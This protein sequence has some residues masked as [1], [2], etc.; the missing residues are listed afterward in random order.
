M[1]KMLNL[2]SANVFVDL[3]FAEIDERIPYKIVA[4]MVSCELDYSV[5]RQ[6]ICDIINEYLDDKYTYLDAYACADK[7][8]T[9]E[10]AYDT[11]GSKLATPV[12][13]VIIDTLSDVLNAVSAMAYVEYAP[14]VSYDF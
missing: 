1:I 12:R 10:Q 2:E 4:S 9:Y 13:I 11:F 5:V 3:F 8:M 6:V 7:I 14:A